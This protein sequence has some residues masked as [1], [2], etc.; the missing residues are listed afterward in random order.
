MMHDWGFWCRPDQIPPKTHD[1]I[2]W[3]VLGGRGAGKTR[4]GSEWVT[5][6][7]A[8]GTRSIAIVGETYEDAREVMIEGPSGLCSVGFPE[9]RPVYES[10]RHRVV[11]PNGA[12]GHAFS[13]EDPEGLRGFQFEAAWADELCKWM[14]PE[15]AWSNLQFGLRLGDRPRQVVTTTPK[16]LPLLKKLLADDR[17][18]TTR[19]ATFAN[20]GHLADAFLTQIAAAYEGTSLGRQELLGE[21]VE[22]RQGALWTSKLLANALVHEI[23]QL[24]RIIVA[25]DPPV[26]SGDQ[27]DECGI[28]VAGVLGE[29]I[30]SVAY[31]LEDAS[32]QG[33]SP[34]AWA[35]RA[36]ALLSKY[37]ADRVIAEVNQGGDLVE[38]MLR[39][40]DHSVPY[41]A[42]RASRGK[43][44]RAEPVAALYEKGRVRH[45]K[46]FPQLEEQLI[47]FS[48]AANEGSPDRLD[49]L[50]WAV[51]ELLLTQCT[52]HPSIRAL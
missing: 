3:L 30:N 44:A 26:T 10:S 5:A 51:T 7:I 28:I 2:T 50:V 49:A 36:V 45:A 17:T 13:A 19:A 52:A 40:A 11:W 32:C 48:G 33:L 24:S 34:S 8:Q 43:S 27:S 42:V 6:Q 46:P 15:E 20:K 16:P 31:I 47:N 21:I 29:G 38:E 23:P 39:L 1:W 41:R 37:Q 9:S 35:A 14:Y 12:T 22:D 18:T 25:I 4:T